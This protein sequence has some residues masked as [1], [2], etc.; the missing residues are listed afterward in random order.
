M[1]G[2]IMSDQRIDDVAERRADDDADGE[3]HDLAA[4]GERFEFSR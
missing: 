3:V 1:G 4:H 2:M